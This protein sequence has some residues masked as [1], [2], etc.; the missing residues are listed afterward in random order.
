[1]LRALR[2]AWQRYLGSL[3]ETEVVD[4]I[5]ESQWAQAEHRPRLSPARRRHFGDLVALLVAHRPPA[6][7]AAWVA[8]AQAA[9]A[10]LG[11]IDDALLQLLQPPDAGADPTDAAGVIV[12]D[13]KAVDELPWQAERLCRAHG[14]PAD[15]RSPGGRL[16]EALASLDAWLQPQGL[17]LL[18]LAAGDTAVAWAVRA[19]SVPVGRALGRKLRLRI[20]GPGET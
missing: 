3:P 20:G 16:D 19:E 5:P 13:W 6:E 10:D 14:L 9:L 4:S 1:M 8:R 15:W 17:R 11:E 12:C 18:T 2:Q 7:V